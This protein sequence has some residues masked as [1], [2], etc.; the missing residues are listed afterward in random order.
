MGS[1]FT[2]TRPDYPV[3]AA[4]TRRV[5]SWAALRA[6]R[7]SEILAQV[8][9]Q[10]AFWSSVLHLN[11]EIVPYTHELMMVML[12]VASVV[13]Q[14]V[15]YEAVVPRPSDFSARIQP[16]I[17][18]PGFFAWPSGHATQAFA[19]AELL[20]VLTMPEGLNQQSTHP[21][22]QA[23]RQLFAQADR[24]AT[25][26][27]VAGLHFPADNEAGCELGIWLAQRL[28]FECTKQDV[29]AKTTR[30]DYRFVFKNSEEMAHDFRFIQHVEQQASY[31]LGYQFPVVDEGMSLEVGAL[32]KRR[33]AIDTPL[34]WLWAM[35]RNEWFNQGMVPA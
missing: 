21:W 18:N 29:R 35:A 19:V 11:P 31:R 15:K 23:W 3:F 24:I 10:F 4:Q 30:N 33:I 8:G 28:V 13:V 34:Q 26:R 17:E 16:M 9:P 22:V 12:E 6:E 7:S 5:E 20:A 25:N 1:T 14:K 27:V 32:V 2:L